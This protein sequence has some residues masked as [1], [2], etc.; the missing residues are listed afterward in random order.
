MP[1][2]NVRVPHT[3]ADPKAALAAVRSLTGRSSGVPGRIDPNDSAVVVAPIVVR[4]VSVLLAGQP[5]R[6]ES[7]QVACG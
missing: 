6:S 1:I 2:G 7:G 4:E 5:G 3:S